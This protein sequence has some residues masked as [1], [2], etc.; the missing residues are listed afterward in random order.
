MTETLRH[1][2]DEGKS[3]LVEGKDGETWI[4]DKGVTKKVRLGTCTKK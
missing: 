2:R 1:V 3:V 4:R